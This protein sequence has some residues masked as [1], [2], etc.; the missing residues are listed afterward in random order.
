MFSFPVNLIEGD[1]HPY[2][3]DLAAE[4]PINKCL[5]P[6]VDYLYVNAENPRRFIPS[7]ESKI[8]ILGLYRNRNYTSNYYQNNED[9]QNELLNLI[10]NNIQF[11]EYLQFLEITFKPAIYF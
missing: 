9:D 5:L 4:R 2:Y 6:I 7:I 8:I 11:Q 10:T 1:K 3:E